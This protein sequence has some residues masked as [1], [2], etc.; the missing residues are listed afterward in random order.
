[1]K[2]SNPRSIIRPGYLAAPALGIA[3]A[4]RTAEPSA[5]PKDAFKEHF[6]VGTAVNRNMVAEG[7]S[8]LRPVD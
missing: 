5:A 3:T 6:L 2:P 7:A 8:Q 4:A 1:M